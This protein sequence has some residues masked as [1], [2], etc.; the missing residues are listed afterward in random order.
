MNEEQLPELPRLGEL[1]GMLASLSTRFE[2]HLER[3][4]AIGM[5]N[6]HAEDH[7]VIAA[8]RRALDNIQG[9]LAMVEQKNQ[10]SLSITIS[11]GSRPSLGRL[12]A[13]TQISPIPARTSPTMTNIQPKPLFPSAPFIYA[14]LAKTSP[15]VAVRRSLPSPAVDPRLHESS[16]GPHFQERRL[17]WLTGDSVERLFPLRTLCR[18]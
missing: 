9:M 2:E 18:A 7:L 17:L 1:V 4:I 10:F 3:A 15:L 13:R 12:G 6:I 11:P 14:F 8:L 16:L 5:N